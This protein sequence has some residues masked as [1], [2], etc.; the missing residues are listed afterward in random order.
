MPDTYLAPPPWPVPCTVAALRRQ[1]PKGIS[2]TIAEHHPQHALA[3]LL[4]DVINDFDFPG[5]ESLIAGAAR[6]APRRRA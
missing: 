1:S 6:A 4:I 2:L 5:A 3:F